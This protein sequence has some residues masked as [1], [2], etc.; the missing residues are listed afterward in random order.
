MARGALT[1]GRPLASDQIAVP[2]EQRLRLRQ[3]G[4]QA[5]PW[6]Q[7]AEAGQQDAIT[8]LPG[9][10]ADLPLQRAELMPEG[11]DLGA[12]LGVG[13]GADENEV[14]DEADKLVREAEKHGD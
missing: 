1:E 12:E 2:A 14:N 13:A 7:P 11:E 10:L 6:E 9:R 5:G 8:R 4:P 3:Q